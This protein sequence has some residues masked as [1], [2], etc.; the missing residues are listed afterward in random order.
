MPKSA[1]SPDA[2]RRLVDGRMVIMS[3]VVI[4]I[5]GVFESHRSYDNTWLLVQVVLVGSIFQAKVVFVLP[6]WIRRWSSL[7]SP[8]RF[9]ISSNSPER[10]IADNY[11]NRNY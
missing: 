10:Y 11:G 3:S 6:Y 4:L 5:L 7:R 2:V 8:L 9:K 1:S